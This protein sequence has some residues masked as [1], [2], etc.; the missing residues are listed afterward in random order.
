MDNKQGVKSIHF[1]RETKKIKNCKL[2]PFLGKAKSKHG[3][4]NS[5]PLL[6]KFTNLRNK[7]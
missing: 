7:K 5:K 6:L 3:V 1:A 2:Y 4:K